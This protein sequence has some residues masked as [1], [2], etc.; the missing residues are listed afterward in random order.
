M[1]KY[2]SINEFSPYKERLIS[3]FALPTLDWG[4]IFRPQVWLFHILSPAKA[5]SAYWL[6]LMLSMLTSS[7]YLLKFAGL[8]RRIAI[9]GSLLL[10]FS[11]YI[12]LWWTMNAGVFAFIAWV[13]VAM[14]ANVGFFRR[15]F[16]I[17]LTT[18]VTLFSFLYPPFLIGGGLAVGA[19]VLATSPHRFRDWQFL[20]AVGLGVACA[21]LCAAFYY[22]D[23]YTAIKDTVY[24]G[25]RVANGGGLNP[26]Q[27]LGHVLPYLTTTGQH[28]GGADSSAIAG[29]NPI[30]IAVIGSWLPLLLV[31]F[32]ARGSL[33]RALRENLWFISVMTSLLVLLLLWMTTSWVDVLFGITRLNQMPSYRALY[34]FGMAFLLTQ[35]YLAP[36]ITFQFTLSRFFIFGFLVIISGLLS[37]LIA[38]E[39][40]QF[41]EGV[42]TLLRADRSDYVVFVPLIIAAA[43]WWSLAAHERVRS[44]F[45]SPVPL[46]L[47]ASTTSILTFGLF[48]PV[49]STRVIFEAPDSP[50]TR[51]LEQAQKEPV[52]RFLAVEGGGVLLSGL[53][54]NVINDTLLYPQLDF[55]RKLYP[56]IPDLEFL[57]IFNRYAHIIIS[58]GVDHP[59]LL[60][61]DAIVLPSRT[62]TMVSTSCPQ[63]LPPDF[64]AKRYLELQ[65]DVA[66]AGMDAGT[67]YLL[68]GCKENRD[69]R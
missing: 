17:F 57:N 41:K 8:S 44:L 14:L 39:S 40:G 66:E 62:F 30:E 1:N 33:C 45:S 6:T 31:I 63:S 42:L 9:S 29:L 51:A 32:A 69:Y 67:H 35:I 48:N 5:Y 21:S 49:Q 34:G 68:Y 50:I 12:Q 60:Q 38:K 25:R 18:S 24:P 22:W 56:N 11:Q 4:L 10:F 65:P 37:T 55:F 13:G 2:G 58:S 16:L 47:I 26:I 36:R 64:N 53:G 20:F 7:Y 52:E 19:F 28:E 15:L 3:F 27:L 46:L 54:Y 23:L 61:T 43:F 59:T